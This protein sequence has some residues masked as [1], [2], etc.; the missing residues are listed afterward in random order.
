[1]A[2][3]AR[4]A[5]ER[6]QASPP[7]ARHLVIVVLDSLRYDVWL[8]A[9]TPNL[10]RLGPV[11]RRWSYASW[12]SPSHFN[13]LTG[14][15]PH[16]SPKHV[17]ASLLYRDEYERYTDRLRV[18][19]V[20]LAG[21]LPELWLPTFLRDQLGY[22]TGALV[23]M[24]VLNAAT[25]LNRGF[26]HYE[27]MPRHDDFGAMVDRL[28]LGGDRP[29]FWLLNVGE[30]HYPYTVAGEPAPDL[31]VLHG[32]HGVVRA[33]GNDRASD[34]RFDPDVV[35][36]LRQRQVRALEHVDGT[37]G[38]LF[39][40][41]PADTWLMVTSDHGELFGEDGYFGHGP[42]NHEKVFEVPFVEGIN[43]GIDADTD[44]GHK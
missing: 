39:R 15:P 5:R 4:T 14:L 41:L 22:R 10:D 29:W 33:L 13:L 36:E 18:P 3:D 17:Y 30:T 26:D 23:S 7:G 38:Q 28:D 8:E 31:P 27:L 6:V 24:P 19:R 42:V 2:D 20:D 1:M 44:R 16:T 32:V 11:E 43:P 25:G 12:T 21:L 35:T 37:F 40:R 9:A 34:S